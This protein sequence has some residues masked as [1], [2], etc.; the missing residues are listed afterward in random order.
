VS[1]QRARSEK[2]HYG[3]CDDAL[4]LASLTSKRVSLSDRPSSQILEK[5]AIDSMG[6][7][8]LLPGREGPEQPSHDERDGLSQGRFFIR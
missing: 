4:V 7:Q 1:G 2:L 8:R 5:F 3:L 6:L